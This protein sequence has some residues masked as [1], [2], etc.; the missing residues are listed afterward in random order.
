MIPDIGMMI[1]AYI[2]TRMAAMLGQ[3]LQQAN[4]TA[5]IFGGVTILIT[6]IC[7]LDLLTKTTPTFR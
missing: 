7:A 1:A 6:L 2:I 3:P 5:K 4:V